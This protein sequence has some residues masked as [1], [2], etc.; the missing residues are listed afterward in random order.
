MVGV[1]ER[2][3]HTKV[4]TSMAENENFDAI[5][6]LG[7]IG[8]ARSYM[9]HLAKFD[10]DL[11]GTLKPYVLETEAK[12]IRKIAELVETLQK[13]IIAVSLRPE[14]ALLEIER[15]GC[16]IT[17]FSS[18]DQAV[19]ALTAMDRYRRFLEKKKESS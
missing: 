5:I 6:A 19:R 4:L 14:R 15:L 10:P 2:Q 7:T 8:T 17:L 12:F 1:L 16:Q 11:A 13:P 3:I 18:P 9:E